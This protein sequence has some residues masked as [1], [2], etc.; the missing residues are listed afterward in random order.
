[1]LN[2]FDL[3]S[4]IIKFRIETFGPVTSGTHITSFDNYVLPSLSSWSK[5]S[6]KFDL[7]ISFYY[8]LSKIHYENTFKEIF[9]I[10]GTIT[11]SLTIPG[12]TFNILYHSFH[13]WNHD[14]YR[15]HLA[16]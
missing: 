12:I 3:I 8:L 15:A 1:M 7:S 4:N 6:Q 5:K 9:V 2:Y 14:D 16:I 11:T 10:D 13:Y